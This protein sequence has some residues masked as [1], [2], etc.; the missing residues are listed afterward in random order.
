MD[1]R[2]ELRELSVTIGGRKILQDIHLTLKRGEVVA[3][4]GESGSGKSTLSKALMGILPFQGEVLFKGEPLNHKHIGREVVLVPQNSMNAFN[5]SIKV[6]KQLIDGVLLHRIDTRE[7]AA[8]KA[9]LLMEEFNLSRDN[10][11]RY[12]HELS[13]GMKQRM[14]FIMGLLPDPEFLILDE[15]TTGLDRLNKAVI[16]D[17][18]SEIRN[19]KG[20]LLI[21]HELDLVRDLA[22]WVVVLKNGV[23]VEWG[24]S[25]DILTAPRHPYVRELVNSLIENLSEEMTPL[26]KLRNYKDSRCCPFIEHCPHAMNIC[27]RG[28]THVSGNREKGVACWK[29]YREGEE[30]V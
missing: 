1:S 10:Y 23:A 17:K 8:V 22:D 4:V 12:P 19:S 29:Y 9:K 14:A 2:L 5:P 11:D 30:K 13:G 15:V 25:K 20:I 18:V 24:A 3:V 21:S 16:L 26:K 28:K 6:G 27:T 7:G